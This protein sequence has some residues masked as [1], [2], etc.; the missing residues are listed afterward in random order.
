MD[1]SDVIRDVLIDTAEVE[2]YHHHHIILD[3]VQLALDRG[4]DVA[5]FHQKFAR[6]PPQ[7]KFEAELVEKVAEWLS[8]KGDTEREV[9]LTIPTEDAYVVPIAV[10]HGF[11]FVNAHPGQLMMC[12][13]LKRT[14]FSSD[15]FD[16]CVAHPFCDASVLARPGACGAPAW[17][18]L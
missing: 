18:S 2:R 9:R 8:S 1:A 7:D 4:V 17:R 13:R 3:V 14:R 10:K 16:L 5:L 6:H 11:D 12:L 15:G